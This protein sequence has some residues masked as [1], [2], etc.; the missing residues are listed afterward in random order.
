MVK[1]VQ[2]SG[3][4][5]ISV[6]DLP[7]PV[8]T[9]GQVRVKVHRVGVCGTDISLLAGKLPFACYPIVPGHELA[10]EIIETAGESSFEIGA[11]VA[12]NPLEHCGRR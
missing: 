1:A 10:G 9:P 6:V 3:P 11:R 7:R 5:A 2:V 8:L 4:T 12:A